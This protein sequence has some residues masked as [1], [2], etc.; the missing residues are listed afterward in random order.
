MHNP[1]NRIPSHGPASRQ[2]YHP[3][4]QVL[5]PL[6]VNI[7]HWKYVVGRMIGH[8]LLIYMSKHTFPKMSTKDSSLVVVVVVGMVGAVIVVLVVEITLMV[9][10][11][12]NMITMTHDHCHMI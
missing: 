4:F 2:Y 10:V 11:E 12:D 1:L 8:M 9:T 6:G 3:N 5:Y 7:R